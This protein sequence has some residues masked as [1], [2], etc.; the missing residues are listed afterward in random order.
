MSWTITD[1]DKRTACKRVLSEQDYEPM[2]WERR[3]ALSFD[4]TEQFLAWL[5]P[6]VPGNEY[7]WAVEQSTYIQK[8]ESVVT[9]PN[10]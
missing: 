10:G 4:G 1:D 3:L 9:D 2:E 5:N 6:P 7:K 8:R